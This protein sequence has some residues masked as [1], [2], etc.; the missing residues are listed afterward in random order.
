MASKPRSINDWIRRY[1][2]E[3]EPR[4]KSL[5]ITMFGDSLSPAVDAVW[6]GELIELLEPF[7]VNERLVRTSS[8]R[9]VEEGWLESQRDGRRSR[10]G[11]TPSGARRFELAYRRIYAPRLVRWDGKWTV[12]VLSKAGNG[13]AERS[14]LRHELGWEGFGMLAPGVFLHP[15]ADVGSL[16]DVL[17]ELELR[18]RAVVLTASDLEGLDARPVT[19]LAGECWNLEEVSQLYKGFLDRFEPVAAL[20]ADT[21]TPESAFALQT[22]LIH[23][24]RRVSLHDPRLPAPLLPDDWPGHAAYDLCRNLYQLTVRGTQKHL[25]AKLP[26]MT[27]AAV[28]AIVL[29]RFGGL[30]K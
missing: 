11:L 12:V 8:F 22:L 27:T 14:E 30:S 16:G 5:I 9:L 18:Q 29:Q 4:S 1:L 7:D 20:A 17:D 3:E 23:S 10:Y 28:P 19:E 13:A 2:K 6:L 25:K 26:S 21:L 15:S 24:F